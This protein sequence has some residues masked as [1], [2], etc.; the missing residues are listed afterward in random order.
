[1]DSTQHK[2]MGTNQSKRLMAK[3]V[4]AGSISGG[5]ARLILTFVEVAFRFAQSSARGF[6]KRRATF[7]EEM[8][9]PGFGAAM[10]NYA[11]VLH[12][13]CTQKKEFGTLPP[14]PKDETNLPAGFVK[15]GELLYWGYCLDRAIYLASVRDDMG[16]SD[17]DWTSKFQDVKAAAGQLGDRDFERL[18][19]RRRKF[20]AAK[21]RDY[22]HVKYALL[23]HWVSA[24]LWCTESNEAQ[25]DRLKNAG[26]VTSRLTL[27]ALMRARKRMGLRWPFV[28]GAYTPMKR[29]QHPKRVTSISA[30]RSR[31]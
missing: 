21:H 20:Q 17:V 19:E 1:M 11:Q 29:G 18:A 14:L 7:E 26:L 31:R 30:R 23:F 13:W 6:L 12:H 2:L 27:A 22:G 25:L 24:G 8:R 5:R 10:S 4:S 3:K 15:E 28:E 9:L 16:A